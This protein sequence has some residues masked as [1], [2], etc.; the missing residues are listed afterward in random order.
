MFL[1]LKSLASRGCS[2]HSRRAIVTQKPRAR[3][4]PSMSPPDTRLR[5][6]HALPVGPSYSLDA[7]RP[8]NSVRRAPNMLCWRRVGRRPRGV[9]AD[10]EADASPSPLVTGRRRSS[11]CVWHRLQW[12]EVAQSFVSVESSWP[13][14]ITLTSRNSPRC[15]L[16]RQTSACAEITDSKSR[17]TPSACH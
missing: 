6:L 5:R 3:T 1:E 2:Q 17:A 10:D 16:F 14:R 15:P 9:V 7:R 11:E 12:W 4:L 13:V 8:I